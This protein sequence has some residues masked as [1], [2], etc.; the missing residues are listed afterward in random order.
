VHTFDD[1]QVVVIPYGS[2][3]NRRWYSLRDDRERVIAHDENLSVHGAEGDLP[4]LKAIMREAGIA[5]YMLLHA[6]KCEHPGCKRLSTTK[7]CP[8]HAD[9]QSDVV[10]C[11]MTGLPLNENA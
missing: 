4:R 10:F 2:M 11:M 8:A 5:T 6:H 3:S 9:P 1:A 7:Y